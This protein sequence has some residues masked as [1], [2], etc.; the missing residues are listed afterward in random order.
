MLDAY[1]IARDAFVFNLVFTAECKAIRMRG[2]PNS[3]QQRESAHR[4]DK[5]LYFYLHFGPR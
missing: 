2:R 4:K 1:S 3:M 5:G